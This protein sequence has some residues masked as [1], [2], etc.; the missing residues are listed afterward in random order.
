MALNRKFL[1]TP[2]RVERTYRSTLDVQHITQGYLS[3]DGTEVRVRQLNEEYTLTM[4][5]QNGGRRT[6]YTHQLVKGEYDALLDMSQPYVLHKR[7]YLHPMG[8][9]L[10]FFE[11]GSEPIVEY[12]NLHEVDEL[13]KICAES[14]GVDL[15]REV[16]HDPAYQNRN[17]A[18]RLGAMEQS[19]AG[20][21][22]R[23]IPKGI[24]GEVSKIREELEELEDATIQRVKVLQLVEL[25][26][27]VGACAHYA[28]TL[29]VSMDDLLAMSKVTRRAFANGAR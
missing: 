29:G 21:H 26:D 4:T 16:T 3:F 12:A 11:A 18:L 1:L 20:Y 6:R 19:A 13:T 28:E 27:L 14:W 8:F 9:V 24:L 17:I 7:R 22:L 2:N 10:D 25:S 15:S 5:Q 23:H